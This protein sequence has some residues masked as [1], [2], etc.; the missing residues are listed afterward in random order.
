MTCTESSKLFVKN[1]FIEVDERREL[2]GAVRRSA[3][4]PASL[5]AQ[6]FKEE[7]ELCVP[8][9]SSRSKCS[10]GALSEDG[11][12]SDAEPSTEAFGEFASDG[13]SSDAGGCSRDDIVGSAGSCRSRLK[14]SARAYKPQGTV[15]PLAL[16]LAALAAVSTVTVDEADTYSKEVLQVVS[17]IKDT[18]A[19]IDSSFLVEAVHHSLTGWH[20][21][22]T[23]PQELIHS[24]EAL[25]TVAKQHLLVFAEGS[26]VTYVLGYC[27]HPFLA[28]PAGFTCTLVAL[29][30]TS[31][32]CW[33]F[34]K[35][36]FCKRC[37]I[38]RWQ[39]PH[40]AV[41]LSVDLVYSGATP[42]QDF[43]CMVPLLPQQ[44]QSEE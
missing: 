32:A 30:D 15:L 27:G 1:T 11:T 34:Y 24:S 12:S 16:P 42:L 43:C 29:E 19:A 23:V 25:L 37:T 35:W 8:F 21:N 2:P 31:T 22:V 6:E 14:S 26:Q 18:L 17:Y 33:D 9:L 13:S 39:H 20:I 44:T 36:G 38:C 3:S 4:L 5:R 10:Q 28:Q 41:R 40:R 7:V